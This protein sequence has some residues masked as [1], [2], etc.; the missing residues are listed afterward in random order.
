M[1][2]EEQLLKAFWTCLRDDLLGHGRTSDN[3]PY[4]QRRL[5]YSERVT[6]E[7]GNLQRDAHLF[8][9]SPDFNWWANQSGLDVDYLRVRLYELSD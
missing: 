8:V 2:P 9:E 5:P 1:Q 3:L 7:R 6:I 4:H